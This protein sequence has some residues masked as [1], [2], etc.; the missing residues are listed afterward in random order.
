[1]VPDLWILAFTFLSFLLKNL[2]LQHS[3]VIPCIIG[4]LSD[5]MLPYFWFNWHKHRYKMGNLYEFYN[6]PGHSPDPHTWGVTLEGIQT[7]G[8]WAVI[9]VLDSTMLKKRKK[10]L[11]IPAFHPISLLSPKSG[12][13]H[14]VCKNH[15]RLFFKLRTYTCA[16]QNTLSIPAGK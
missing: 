1:M 11:L 2:P 12:T 10:S 15:S 6:L 4:N 7:A 8:V 9:H 16:S 13:Y 3:I 5:F 14:C